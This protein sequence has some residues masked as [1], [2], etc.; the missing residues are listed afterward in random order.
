MYFGYI[1]K[2][3]A[4]LGKRDELQAILLEAAAALQS[5]PDCVHYLVS[6]TNEPGTIWVTEAW[7]SK[8]AHDAS[9]EPEAVKAVIT[10]ATSLIVSISNQ[11]ELQ[12][13]GGKGLNR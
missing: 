4:K 12:I 9:L 3:T 10:Q 5:N 13:A 7:A 1:I 6:T 11:V 8:E 2:F